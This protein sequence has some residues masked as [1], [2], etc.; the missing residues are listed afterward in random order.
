MFHYYIYFLFLTHFFLSFLSVVPLVFIAVAAVIAVAVSNF[1]F[2]SSA[3][4][5]AKQERTA[6]TGKNN[7][8]KNN[9]WKRENEAPKAA[10]YEGERIN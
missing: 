6:V 1:T 7:S 10:E 5:Y 9:L 4:V 8:K 2:L 3:G